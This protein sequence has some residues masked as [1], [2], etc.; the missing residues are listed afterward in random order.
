MQ[1]KQTTNTPR[2]HTVS[3][4]PYK[5]NC[6]VVTHEGSTDCWIVDASYDPSE[7][8]KWVGNEG[9]EPKAV[10]LTHAHEDHIAGLF[11]VARAFPDAEICIHEAER[12][13][14]NNPMLNLSALSG[15]PITGP[16][17]TRFLQPDEQ[18]TLAD[19]SWKVLYT[20]GHSPGGI[21][22]YHAPSATAFVGDTLFAGAVGRSDF[23]GSDTATLA[24]SIRDKLYTLPDHTRIFP[25][26]G[27]PSTIGHEKRTNPFVRPLM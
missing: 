5:T 16:E 26:H 9:L 25:G 12:E 23:P 4:G 18:L 1:S 20:P 2:I 3:L 13:W 17:P 21:A 27:P 10:M 11:E 19:Q 6:Y 8:I 14:L 22:L 24:R 15:V 7:L